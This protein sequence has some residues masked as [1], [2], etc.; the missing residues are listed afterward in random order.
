[1]RTGGQSTPSPSDAPTDTSDSVVTEFASQCNQ[2]SVANPLKV[3]GQKHDK[4]A[5]EERNVKPPL[6]FH[7]RN[8]SRSE[9]GEA[10][11]LLSSSSE[12]LV[13]KRWL[14]NA[15]ERWVPPAKND[16]SIEYGVDELQH[17]NKY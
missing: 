15:S 16:G 12:I 9:G 17:E 5:L 2:W 8:E 10:R 14:S 11:P 4:F 3:T 13:Q 1:M 7:W 6:Y